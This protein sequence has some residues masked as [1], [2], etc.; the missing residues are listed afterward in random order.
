MKEIQLIFFDNCDTCNQEYPEYQF[1]FGYLNLCIDCYCKL[2]N[3][4]QPKVVKS[5]KTFYKKVNDLGGTVI[6]EYKGSK[7][8]VDCICKNGHSCKPIP[9]GIQ[10]GEGMCRICAGN[11]SETAKQNFYKNI[12]NLGGKVIGE[13]KNTDT[14]VECICKEGHPCNPRPH[15]I[16]K[17]EGMCIIC[18]GKDSETAKQNFYKNIENLGGKVIG[19]YINS[20]TPVECICKEGHTCNPIPN[21]IQQGQG[22]CR[23]CAGKDS[24]TAK[25]NFYKNIENLGGTVTGEYKDAHTPVECICSEGHSCNPMPNNIQQGNGMCRIC[26]GTD[27]ETAKQNFFENIKNLG[28][29]VTGEYK[30]KG[31]PVDCICQNGHSCSPRPNGIQQGQGMCIIC[32]GKDS[33]TAKQNFYK[34]IENLG[35]KVIGEYKNTDTPVECICKYDH[36]CNPIPNGIQQG[37]GMCRICAGNDSETA[38]QNFYKNIENLGGTVTGEYKGAHTPVECICSEG[39]S[40]NPRPGHIQQGHGM[41]GCCSNSRGYSKK[42]IDWFNSISNSI[43]HAE[44]GGEFK[45]PNIGK[46]D[47]YDN[48]TNT[49]Y[50]F[51]GC[52]WHGC[53]R[54]FEPDYFNKT[55]KK[56]AS[57]L[58][59]KTTERAL[60]I[61][62][63]GYNLIEMWECDFVN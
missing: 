14:P 42:A 35:G 26:V 12:E 1:I 24:E 5:I 44:N 57:D 52:Y 45:I 49:V 18:A 28:G 11:D 63:A 48:K 13:Y 40:C 22:M 54:C 20:S 61:R 58:Y 34:N 4:K 15:G 53:P 8:K 39:H 47:G 7:I 55:S 2:T 60:A 59:S 25:Q 9:N 10:Q 37:H 6:G 36:P 3:K 27:F 38:K 17:G 31:I 32:A 51:H 23:I 41:C 56:T 33:E 43:Q 30:G 50:E 29:T 62:N 46:V 16:Q 21:G 19:D